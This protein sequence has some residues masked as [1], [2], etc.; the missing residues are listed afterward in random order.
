MRRDIEA[1]GNQGG[2][3]VGSEIDTDVECEPAGTIPMEEM[4]QRS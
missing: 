3:S 1:L 4:R 2:T